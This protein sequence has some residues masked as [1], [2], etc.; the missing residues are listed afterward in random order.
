[1]KRFIIGVVVAFSSEKETK[2]KKGR[3]HFLGV[4]REHNNIYNTI[5][6]QNN[7]NNKQ[8]KRTTNK[9]IDK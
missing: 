6:K 5:N 9:E 1:M 4:Q 3:K 8:V 7:I 2:K